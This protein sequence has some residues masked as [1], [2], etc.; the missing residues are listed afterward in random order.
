[1]SDTTTVYDVLAR[2]RLDGNPSAA[3]GGVAQAAGGAERSIMGVRGAFAALGALAAGG[4]GI[5]ALKR[6]FIDFNS[7]IEQSKIAIASVDRLFS[8]HSFVQSQA[9]AEEFFS[10]YQIAAKKSTATTEEFLSAHQM[11][12]PAL[13]KAGAAGQQLRDIVQGS[14]IAAPTLGFEA[15]MAQLDIRSMLAGTV[16]SKDQFAQM[17]LASLGLAVDTFNAKAKSDPKY[18]L[19]ILEKS[20]TQDAFKDAANAME[21][22]FSGV[23]ST[24]KDTLAILGGVAGKPLFTVVTA[25]LSKIN[26]Y[27]S[28]NSADIE[29]MARAFGGKMVDGFLAIGQFMQ[30]LSENK[31]SL[32]TIASLYAAFSTTSAAAGAFGA[33]HSAATNAAGGLTSA[34]GAAA[35]L[36]GA[37]GALYVGL[38]ALAVFADRSQKASIE[39]DAGF[40]PL[41]RD[42]L[43]SLGEHQYDR[44]K[45]LRERTALIKQVDE[46]GLLKDGQLNQKAFAAQLG[47][48]GLNPWEAEDA[49]RSVVDMLAK[50]GPET[51]QRALAK[52]QGPGWSM[53]PGALLPGDV[54][55]ADKKSK[56]PATVKVD[57]HRI[58]VAS[59]DP[60]RFAM[61]LVGSFR[62]A[63][64]RPTESGFSLPRGD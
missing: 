37:L 46:T 52:K 35:T 22:S 23:L 54:N 56:T 64:E 10:A 26:D 29:R 60:D 50:A 43:K 18:A 15:K 39:Q 38:Q 55:V 57:I 21:G 59:D 34:A 40:T 45:F 24:L 51:I 2:F 63:A 48:G 14:V 41:L 5:G 6:S 36:V 30:V 58:E 13:M 61:Q 7:S 32:I 49:T 44:D 27:M 53:L 47:R 8:G 31:E 16:S 25:E 62:R 1:M 3:M 20:L 17:L 19:K 9:I 42:R 33:L 12:A 28:K 11:L 4:Y